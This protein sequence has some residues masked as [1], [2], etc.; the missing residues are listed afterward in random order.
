MA[1]SDLRGVRKASP[2]SVPLLISCSNTENKENSMDSGNK[3]RSKSE[4]EVCSRVGHLSQILY[5]PK[6][7]TF[8]DAEASL[9]LRL[10]DTMDLSGSSARGVGRNGSM[11]TRH[12]D[13]PMVDTQ[14]RDCS[15]QGP[16]DSK[17]FDDSVI[18][19]IGDSP[20]GKDKSIIELL[21]SKDD[22]KLDMSESRGSGE[23]GRQMSEILASNSL[24]YDNVDNLDKV[25]D[26]DEDVQ[27]MLAHQSMDM[28]DDMEDS[29]DLFDKSSEINLLSPH[30]TNKS[31]KDVWSPKKEIWSA[32]NEK[33][34]KLREVSLSPTAEENCKKKVATVAESEV[35]GEEGK[36]GEEDPTF[37]RI[38]SK[39]D[40]YIDSGSEISR[41]GSSQHMVVSPDVSWG[42]PLPGEQDMKRTYKPNQTSTPSATTNRRAVLS[43]PEL[44]RRR[45]LESD[46]EM[47]KER[48]S[49]TQ[50]QEFKAPTPL[51]SPQGQSRLIRIILDYGHV[52]RVL[53][54]GRATEEDLVRLLQPFGGRALGPEERK[55]PDEAVGKRVKRVSDASS[56]SKSSSGSSGYL[57]GSSGLTSSSEGSRARSRLS[58]MPETPIEK[59][60]VV[61]PLPR[62]TE[63][64]EKE[65]KQNRRTSGD[66]LENVESSSKGE[67]RDQEETEKAETCSVDVNAS[68]SV[69]GPNVSFVDDTGTGVIASQ[70]PG[71]GKDSNKT[72][73]DTKKSRK[74]G[75]K[76]DKEKRLVKKRPK[77]KLEK[78]MEAVEE[79]KDIDSAVSDRFAVGTKVFAKWVDGTGVYFYPADVVERLNTEQAKVRFCE[80]EIEKVLATE[81]D[82]IS[83]HH[84][85]PGDCVTVNYDKFKA[86]EVTASLLQYPSMHGNSV[87]YELAITATE[88][89]PG[90][91]EDSRCVAHR[92]VKLTDS[93]A[94]AILR[95]R[96][97]VPTLNK[98]SAEIN[99]E[100]LCYSKRKTRAPSRGLESP[101]TPRRKKQGGENVEESA[102]SAAAT[103]SST[104]AEEPKSGSGLKRRL[105][106]PAKRGKAGKPSTP[107]SSGVQQRKGKRLVSSDDEDEV[108][109]KSSSRMQAIAE[110]RESEAVSSPKSSSSR[111]SKKLLEIF[112][113]HAFVLNTSSQRPLPM[114][115]VEEEDYTDNEFVVSNATPRFDRK[116]L[117]EIIVMNG[118][119]VLDEFPTQ[120]NPAPTLDRTLI[121][122]S[123]RHSL[124]MTYILAL[125]DG[126]P[127]VSHL[128]LYDC[129]AAQSLQEYKSYL[130]PAGFSC[131]LMRE[132]EQ[133]QD[134]SHD[135]RVNDCLL[136]TRMS[137][138]R[139]DE[140]ASVTGKR[141][142]SGLHVLV[143]SKEEA[144]TEVWQSVLNSLGAAVSRRHDK[145]RLDK[146]RLP[147][148]VVTDSNAH[149]AV[150]KVCF[151]IK[152]TFK[153]H[154]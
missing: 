91:N 103:E 129:V 92:D 142:L 58:L 96:G 26:D 12:D 28:G 1:G 140:D 17:T 134:C 104:S 66:A 105:T 36:E 54:P 94:C 45:N 70:L 24:L 95:G 90:P 125:A 113:G 65:G 109:P 139:K 132:V 86:Y 25:I 115:Y 111:R 33:K 107:V 42:T 44:Q 127:I 149:K 22:L 118:G 99:F 69:T 67:D 102:L 110:A 41:P 114:T 56:L 30:K 97:L 76:L 130:L 16:S 19:I 18:E 126:V 5:S 108:M 78:K 32:K 88:S 128:F 11:E 52:T 106:T 147:D 63:A 144:F 61:A 117:T 39:P 100:N 152:S 21:D 64:V 120:A 138:Q 7:I 10:D 27:S 93:Q 48:G 136:P 55:E 83:A 151:F 82:V 85:S 50:G 141:I 143:I 84:L 119:E 62:M 3:E 98:V 101:S 35:V 79:E 38:S 74:G 20:A 89:E 72:E 116:K 68:S 60:T 46:K 135:L 71:E 81:S 121:V 77:V 80:D 75:K 13:S 8:Q 150:C 87:S 59:H 73:V 43:S 124:T 51:T 154:H 29:I 47:T 137:R 57:G 145:T 31:K 34:R 133:G 49:P 148:V 4:S 122:V 40:T 23:G 2:T 153:S 37:A 112:S 15:G 9:Q 146:L 123:D 53:D 6:Y 14:S 131:L